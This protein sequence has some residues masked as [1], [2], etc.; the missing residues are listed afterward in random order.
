M[1]KK[2]RG[3]TF[4]LVITEGEIVNVFESEEEAEGYAYCVNEDSVDNEIA[5]AGYDS[6]ELDEDEIA[7]FA[8]SAGYNS[9]Y[10]YSEEVRIPEEFNEDDIVCTSQGDEINYSEIILAINKYRKE[11]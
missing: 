4:H 11:D 9:G 2:Y 8:F 5:E 10:T 3:Q 1:S 7:E 6:E